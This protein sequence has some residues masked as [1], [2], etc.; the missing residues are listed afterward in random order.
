MTGRTWLILGIALLL[1]LGACGGAE[2]TGSPAPT[3]ER[4]ADWGEGMTYDECTEQGFTDYG[5]R[6]G[7]KWIGDFYADLYPCQAPPPL[8]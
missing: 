5:I 2:D 6:T 7:Q 8:R 4:A 3:G 1:L